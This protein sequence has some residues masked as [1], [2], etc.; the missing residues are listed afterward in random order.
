MLHSCRFTV[1]IHGDVRNSK[2]NLSAV[3]MDAYFAFTCVQTSS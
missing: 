1:K 2:I 3:P